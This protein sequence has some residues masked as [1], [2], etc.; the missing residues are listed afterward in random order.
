MTMTPCKYIPRPPAEFHIRPSTTTT[1]PSSSPNTPNNNKNSTAIFSNTRSGCSSNLDKALPPTPP[2]RATTAKTTALLK[3]KGLKTRLRTHSFSSSTFSFLTSSSQDHQHFV[4]SPL[5]SSISNRSSSSTVSTT[6]E[7]V[8]QEY[9]RTIKTLWKMVEDEEQAHRLVEAS[10]SLS[11]CI[12]TIA[13]I[14]LGTGTGTGR[15]V[16]RPPYVGTMTAA[17]RRPSLP[18][19]MT[20][21]PIQEEDETSTISTTSP[22]RM[23]FSPRPSSGLQRR[24][25]AVSLAILDKTPLPTTT[26]RNT[27]PLMISTMNEMDHTVADLEV[28]PVGFSDASEEEDSGEDSE[29]EEERA[30]VHIAQKISVYRGRSFCW[31]QPA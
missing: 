28:S 23:P 8:A 17:L 31:S 24:H 16:N 29:E 1:S 7:S 27:F 5:S 2:K 18:L 12:P 4:F 3:L 9:A 20:V 6:R 19:L 22:T 26:K 21:L 15:V 14:S 13:D 25:H 10:H 30:V 11:G